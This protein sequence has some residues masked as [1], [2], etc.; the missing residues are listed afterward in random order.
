MASRPLLLSLVALMGGC[1]EYK[2]TAYEGVDVFFQEPASEVDILLVVD[3]SCS[4]DPYQQELSQN[5]SEFLSFFIDANV[6]YHIGVTTTTI[7]KPDAY[8]PSCPETKIDQIPDPGRLVDGRY[9]DTDTEDAEGVFSE[10]VNVGVC[11]SG[12][13]M[14]LH[15][16]WMALTDEDALADNGDFL[17]P[18]ASL[19]VIFV[20]DEQDYSPKKVNSYINDFRAVKGERERDVFHAS[21]LVVTNL[22]ECSAIQKQSGATKGTRYIDV[23]KQTDGVRG[24]ICD[25]D[26]EDVVTEL[27]LNSSRLQD[28]FFLLSDPDPASLT[29]TVDDTELP[30]ED[31]GWTYDL[32]TNSE[33]EEQAAVIFDR[34]AMPEPGSQITIRYNY[35]GGDPADFCPALSE[36]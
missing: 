13:E 34:T 32:L 33:D 22:D 6:D 3:N 27:S 17:R 19:S 12:Y 2:Y 36:G 16:A 30:C 35:G 11:G 8:P 25:S 10:I 28:T 21:A 18:E 5:F 7:N 4:M 14:G 20:A 31:G 9:I 23:A 29:V 15:A 1:V 24:N 26:F